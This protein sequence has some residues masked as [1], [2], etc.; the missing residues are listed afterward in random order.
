ML[1]AAGKL[2]N[3]NS[4]PNQQAGPSQV[5]ESVVDEDN[6]NNGSSSGLFLVHDCVLGSDSPSNEGNHHSESRDQEKRSSPGLVDRE[7]HSGCNNQ[8]PD[9][10]DAVDQ[11][12]GLGGGDTDL[13][14][15]VADI[16]GYKGVTRQL[17]EKTGANADK[18]SVAVTLGRPEL[19]NAALGELG[20]E[21]DGLLDLGELVLNKFVV[22]VSVGV[23]IGEDDQGLFVAVARNK[24]SGRFRNS[25]DACKHDQGW[26]GLEKAGNSPTPGVMDTESAVGGPGS[27]NLNVN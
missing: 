1:E 27:N 3:L 2:T 18:H 9:R 20:L 15:D 10:Q 6:S 17:G 8:I 23:G 19:R 24:P 16:V 12:L 13:I 25:P 5:I 11:I 26:S 7:R 22:N 4:V 14:E 21:S